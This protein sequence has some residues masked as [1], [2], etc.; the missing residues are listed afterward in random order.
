[1]IMSLHYTAGVLAP[2]F[3]ARL[4]TGTGDILLAMI[5]VSSVPL[6]LYGALIGAVK[7]RPAHEPT[8]G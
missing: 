6:V 1:M 5:L 3:S 4:I 8:A 7:E 2:L